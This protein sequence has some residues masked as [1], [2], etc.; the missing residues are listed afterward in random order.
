MQVVLQEA[1][2]LVKGSLKRRCVTSCKKK[3]PR[4]TLLNSGAEVEISYLLECYFLHFQEQLKT[5]FTK[6]S[7]CHYANYL[8]FGERKMTIFKHGKNIFLFT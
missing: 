7:S 5:Y 2:S 6:K 3:L 4:V 8:S 1:I